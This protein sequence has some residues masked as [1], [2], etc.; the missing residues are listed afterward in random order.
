MFDHTIYFSCGFF[1]FCALFWCG[2]FYPSISWIAN[3]CYTLIIYEICIIY[4]MPLLLLS[5][6]FCSQSANVVYDTRHIMGALHIFFLY[7]FNVWLKSVLHSSQSTVYLIKL[8]HYM[9]F[10]PL[11]NEY[12]FHMIYSRNCWRW[13][14]WRYMINKMRLSKT[15]W[16]KEST[17]P[18]RKEKQ[19]PIETD[20]ENT[21]Q[22]KW[23]C[24]QVKTR[25]KLLHSEINI[26]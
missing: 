5:W 3:Y 13:R 25:S 21:C 11:S 23:K 24:N 20:R 12:Y 8:M 4:W 7:I 2:F 9:R 14:W 16:Q 1:R 6:S 26:L 22:T 17:I 10:F 19:A 18:K 15:M